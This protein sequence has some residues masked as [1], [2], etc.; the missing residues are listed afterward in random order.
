MK[1]LNKFLYLP[2]EEEGEGKNK[3]TDES[4][5]C[6]IISDKTPGFLSPSKTYEL[7]HK[8]TDLEIGC[9]HRAK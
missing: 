7:S 6:R 5:L 1:T 9:K 4:A 3:Q 2:S 8:G